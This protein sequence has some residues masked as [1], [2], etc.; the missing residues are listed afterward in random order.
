MHRSR[1]TPPFPHRIM[2]TIQWLVPSAVLLVLPKCPV[3]FAGW[4]AVTTGVGVSISAA[5]ILRSVLLILCMLA[6]SYL[7]ISRIRRSACKM[8]RSVGVATSGGGTTATPANQT[9]R[10]ASDNHGTFSADR[11][12]RESCCEY[13]CGSTEQPEIKS[14][15]D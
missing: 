1:I 4:I 2:R 13:L 15:K 5:G 3:C 12:W 11:A 8:R 10:N 6:L 7:A 14:G 9:D